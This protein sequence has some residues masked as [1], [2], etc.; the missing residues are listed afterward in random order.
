MSDKVKKAKRDTTTP[1][2]VDLGGVRYSV[3]VYTA[4]Q[5]DEMLADL[6]SGELIE[7]HIADRDNP[8][9]V[10]KAQV[11]LGNVDNTSDKNKPVS[12]A[13]N[14]QLGYKINLEEPFYLH[15]TEGDVNFT[16][17]RLDVRGNRRI[18][19]FS[20]YGM[21][22]DIACTGNSWTAVIDGDEE[23]SVPGHV[24]GGLQEPWM[25]TFT[26][27]DTD[28]VYYLQFIDT[29]THVALSNNPHNVTGQQVGVLNSSGKVAAGLVD[30]TSILNG[31]VT[32]V[33]LKDLSIQ[34][35][36]I[37][38]STITASKLTT[39]LQDAIGKNVNASVSVM[40]PKLVATQAGGIIVNGLDGNWWSIGIDAN[41]DLYKTRVDPPAATT[42]LANE[43]AP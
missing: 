27:E 2:P 24:S 43:R 18:W 30:T 21:T 20:A 8:H 42:N 39:G 11:G 28:Y 41:G 29:V 3:K 1:V 10:T 25:L 40:S 9:E 6:P 36:K 34:N 22:W 19:S 5:I 26:Y 7:Q 4:D 38:N 23:H 16:S 14:S 15:W 33:K 17:D 31:A 32:G 12:D 13:V 37:A 35:S